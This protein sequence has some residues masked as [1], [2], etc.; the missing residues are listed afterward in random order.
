[1]CPPEM[2]FLGHASVWCTHSAFVD[3]LTLSRANFNYFD[4]RSAFQDGMALMAN[5]ANI[6][7]T[8]LHHADCMPYTLSY[9]LFMMKLA[10]T[11]FLELQMSSRKIQIFGLFAPGNPGRICEALAPKDLFAYYTV[12]HKYMEEYGVQEPAWHLPPR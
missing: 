8:P 5:H 1:M 12:L 7:S 9:S 3:S 10:C 4:S 6:A 11:G 2:S